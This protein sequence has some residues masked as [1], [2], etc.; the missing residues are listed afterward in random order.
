LA[1]F[2][3]GQRHFTRGD[4][5]KKTIAWLFLVAVALLTVP[6]SHASVVTSTGWSID[7][8]QPPQEPIPYPG[9]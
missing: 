8:T 9:G 3:K 2:F 7:G 1:A 6:V 5:M 4:F